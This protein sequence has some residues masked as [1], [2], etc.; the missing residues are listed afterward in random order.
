VSDV[1]RVAANAKPA[2]AH[3]R[4]RSS[5]N[6]VARFRGIADP[7]GDVAPFLTYRLHKAVG[8]QAPE[9]RSLEWLSAGIRLSARRH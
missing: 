9:S 6:R 3:N 4:P 8:Q 5:R 1:H 2:R 7:K